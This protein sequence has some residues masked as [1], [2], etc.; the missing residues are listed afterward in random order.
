MPNV[1]HRLKPGASLIVKNGARSAV[2]LQNGIGARAEAVATEVFDTIGAGDSFNAGYLAAR[3]NGHDLSG[4][5]DA[6]CRAAASIISR[7]P[8]R[9][10]A[11]GELAVQI[12]FPRL[13]LAR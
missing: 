11:P 6:G 8:R 2:G 3:L 12:D 5:L 4:A 13:A 9:S 1:A 7:F 10:I